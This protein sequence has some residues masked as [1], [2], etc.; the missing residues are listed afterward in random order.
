MIKIAAGA[1]TPFFFLFSNRLYSRAEAHARSQL[2]PT[3]ALPPVGRVTAP[4]LACFTSR[5]RQHGADT[6]ILVSCFRIVVL[7]R[8]RRAVQRTP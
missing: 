4:A 5:A 2:T 1:G 6:Y 3:G 7:R 8:W